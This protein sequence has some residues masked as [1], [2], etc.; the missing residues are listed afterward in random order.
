[1]PGRGFGDTRPS[2][3]VSLANLNESD[4]AAIGKAIRNLLDDYYA[5]F[6]QR[7]A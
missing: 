3:R 5:R 4:Y 2:A 6:Q 7:K 1:M